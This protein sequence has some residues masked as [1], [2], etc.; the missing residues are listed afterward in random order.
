VSGHGTATPPAAV[1][2]SRSWVPGGSGRLAALGRLAADAD[3]ALFHRVA[4]VHNPALDL[5]LPALSR[6]ADWSRLWLGV[7][8]LLALSGRR[9]AAVRGLASVALASASANGLAKLSVRRVRPPLVVVP[10]VRRVHRAPVTTS[11][12]SGHSASAAAFTVGVALEAP[13][14]AVPVGALAAGVAASRVWTGAHYPGDVV[15]GVALG[16]AA[17]LALARVCRGRRARG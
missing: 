11:F 17:G 12:P 4:G 6:A 3:L 1:P 14:L 7:A 2:L 16:T 5:A 13:E 8:A 15:A 10:L 9:R